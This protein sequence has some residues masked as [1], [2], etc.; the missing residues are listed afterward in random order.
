MGFNLCLGGYSYGEESYNKS[1]EELS[2]A[3]AALATAHLRPP[4]HEILWLLVK[5]VRAATEPEPNEGSM[6]NARA[7]RK[8]AVRA[9][10]K[11]GPGAPQVDVEL[12]LTP[13]ELCPIEQRL[14]WDKAWRWLLA[15]GY[16]ED[17]PDI[18]VHPAASCGEC[19][20]PVLVCTCGGGCSGE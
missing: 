5:A 4:K 10:N 7:V 15:E 11:N 19:Q 20:K 18:H 2:E 12:V 13:F 8:Y 16:R 9:K 17:S 3:I 6:P 14:A 1:P